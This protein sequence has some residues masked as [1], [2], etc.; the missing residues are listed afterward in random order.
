M[1]GIHII[2]IALHF[3]YKFSKIL[4]SIFI[5]SKTHFLGPNWTGNIFEN[6]GSDL[7]S[8]G[9][10]MKLFQ[11]ENRKEKGEKTKN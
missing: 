1:H 2:C 4:R 8:N 6:F 9:I 11:K 7:N 5:L 10:Q 3:E